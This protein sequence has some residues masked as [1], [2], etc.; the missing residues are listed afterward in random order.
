M[1]R[2]GKKRPGRE[3]SEEECFFFAVFAESAVSLPFIY[4]A[5]VVFA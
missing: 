5:V 2:N 1:I 3:N 4:P